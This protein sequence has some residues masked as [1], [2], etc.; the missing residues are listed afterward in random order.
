MAD[1]GWEASLAAIC[2]RIRKDMAQHLCDAGNSRQ[3]SQAPLVQ[4]MELT[5]LADSLYHRGAHRSDDE[6]WQFHVRVLEEVKGLLFHQLR[7]FPGSFHFQRDAPLACR[8][9]YAESLASSQRQLVGYLEGQELDAGL[10][11]LLKEYLFCCQTHSDWFAPSTWSDY[12]YLE[13]FTA[14]L[15]RIAK[16]PHPHPKS[17]FH[18]LMRKMFY[19]NFNCA[20][21]YGFCLQKIQGHTRMFPA[22]RDQHRELLYLLKLC[23]QV[24]EKPDTGFDLKAPSLQASVVKFL[25]EEIRFIVEME[26]LPALHRMQ[27]VPTAPA[28]PYFTVGCTAT[29]LALFMRLLVETGFLMAK[30]K[31]DVH[32]FIA[33]HVGTSKKEK[34]SGHSFKNKTYD[35]SP[36]AA[37]KVKAQLHLMLQRLNEKYLS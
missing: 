19:L 24:P 18:G 14:C 16:L 21:F 15:L 29:Q 5:S 30:R 33:N 35:P 34:I 1:P 22:Y 8:D 23:R 2:D 17:I 32:E 28:R 3:T 11:H 20:P 37:R 26:N 9:W 7:H 36:S 31:A 25:K 6:A 27:G 4:Q 10:R 13:E 12:L